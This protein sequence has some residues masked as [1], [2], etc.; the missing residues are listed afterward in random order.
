MAGQ[1]VE[2]LFLS[3]EDMIKAG[4]L[5]MKHCVQV[6]D[7]M[8]G[9]LATGDYLFGGPKNNEH[10]QK[11]FFPKTTPFPGM[12]VDGPD[13]RFMAMMGYLGGRFHVCGEKWYGSNIINPSRGLPR[14][15]LLVV[16]NDPD[17]CAPL[18]I[19]SAN[20]ASAMRTGAVPGVASKYLARRGAKVCGLVGGGPINKSCLTAIKTAV[21]SIDEVVLYDVVPEKAEKF[22]AEVGDQ[23]KVKT[24]VAKSTEEAVAD[25][26]VISVAAAGARGVKL[27]DS[28]MK[29]GSLLTL[30]GH[31][32]L[33]A[34]YILSTKL[35]TDNWKM[36]EAFLEDAKELGMDMEEAFRSF[37]SGDFL[38][39]I[40]QG[41]LSS[42]DIVD[43]AKVVA[44]MDKGRTSEDERICFVTSGMPS[45]DLAWNYEVYKNALKNGIGQ[46]LKLWDS[47]LWM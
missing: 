28:W 41:K 10:G 14:S 1:K 23:L 40:Q 9:V 2:M 12:P 44:G 7:E 27:K 5:D 17:T 31:G 16:L 29:P 18:T 25:A 36:H 46:K 13:R 35:Y 32:S 45:E 34:S 20:L 11:I 6:I 15:I 24:R 19:N 26:D 22:L 39:L 47:A 21:P 3:E 33:D 43:L 42:S 38:E 4:V 37:V 30:T 8:F